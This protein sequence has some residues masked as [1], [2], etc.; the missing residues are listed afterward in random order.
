MSFLT[1]NFK[2][3]KIV[4]SE[5]VNLIDLPIVPYP[6]SKLSNRI[7]SFYYKRKL[8]AGSNPRILDHFY[9]RS[10]SLINIGNNVQ[11]NKNVTMDATGSLGIYIGSQV[12]FGPGCYLRSA[13][14]SF[15]DDV[16]IQQ[17]GWDCKE[18]SFGKNIAL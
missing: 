2:Y 10:K 13:N 7:R 17:Q 3:A 14:H 11:I 15:S 1:K 4:L 8:L 9:I 16:S 18:I 6:N 12:S 5:I